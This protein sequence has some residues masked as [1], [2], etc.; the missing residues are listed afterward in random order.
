MTLAVL[1]ARCRPDTADED[2]Q[3]SVH[4]T[5]EVNTIASGVLGLGVA[6]TGLRERQQEGENNRVVL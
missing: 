1:D 5:A 2:V 3:P 4:A 6:Q